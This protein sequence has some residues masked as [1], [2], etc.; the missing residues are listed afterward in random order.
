MQGR[1][2]A[3]MLA[4]TILPTPFQQALGLPV[5]CLPIGRA[6]SV[7]DAWRRALR[8]VDGL[9]DAQ[10]VVKS[11]AELTQA[12]ALARAGRR[13]KEGPTI[14]V[15]RDPGAWRGVAGLLRDLTEDRRDD[16][17]V[18]VCEAHCHPPRSLA[19]LLD[20]MDDET[21]G[22]V[23]TTERGEPAGVYAFRAGAF[24]CVSRIGYCDLK[25]QLLPMLHE[26]GQK[27]IAQAVLERARRMRDLDTYLD[28]VRASLSIDDE[29]DHNG[30]RVAPGAHVSRSA[31]LEGFCIV[32]PGATIED[33][34]VV[35]DSVVLGGAV[36]GG[37]AVVSRSVLGPRVR[38]KPRTQVVHTAM[39]TPA[40]V[41]DDVLRAMETEA[42]SP[43]AA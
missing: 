13:S 8:Q 3:I 31:L 24:E 15:V 10:L 29:Q 33:G 32:E 4:G 34:A 25:E 43:S 2:S 21:I 20:A 30:R 18:V 5:L 37:G 17:V 27:V 26:R 42:G 11:E 36:V 23:G 7:L 39:P 41:I 40:G 28:A 6:G 12:E 38:I 35:H 14:D 16:D 19:V 1:V 22:V 9:D